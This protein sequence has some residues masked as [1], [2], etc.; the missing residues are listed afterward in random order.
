MA[1]EA[2]AEAVAA[3][4]QRH[5]SAET[6][7]AAATQAAHTPWPRLCGGR[8]GTVVDVQDDLSPATQ[9][10][11]G[12]RRACEMHLYISARLIL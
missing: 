10:R 4:E 8:C 1:E 6:A 3:G 7:A 12:A 2:V 9:G 5:D 11:G